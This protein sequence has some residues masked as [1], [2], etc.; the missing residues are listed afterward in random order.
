MR[1]GARARPGRGSGAAGAVA[2]LLT[3]RCATWAACPST[4]TLHSPNPSFLSSRTTRATAAK[5]TLLQIFLTILCHAAVAPLMLGP[6]GSDCVDMWIAVLLPRPQRHHRQVI[7]SR[8]EPLDRVYHAGVVH[9][10]VEPN[11][12]KDCLSRASIST[13]T[14]KFIQIDKMLN[15]VFTKYIF[16]QFGNTKINVCLVC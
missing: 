16:V 4:E 5:K 13:T 2:R 6:G 3:V 1:R 15:C 11:L 12:H 9:R 10:T 8:E 14:L 7:R